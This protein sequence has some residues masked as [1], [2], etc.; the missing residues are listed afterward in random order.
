MA[1]APGR[2]PVSH[3]PSSGGVITKDLMQF[4]YSCFNQIILGLI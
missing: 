4:L 3:G 1:G 2:Q